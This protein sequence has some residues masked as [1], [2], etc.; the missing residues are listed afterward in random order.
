MNATRL[1]LISVLV[2]TFVSGC[3]SLHFTQYVV[4]NASATDRATIKKAIVSS[5]EAAGLVDKTE[6][7]KIPDTIVYYLE[8]VPHFPVS[9]GARMVQDSAVVDLSCF[10]PGT[11]KP[12][13]FQSVE[14]NLTATF[15]REFGARLAMPDNSHSVPLT[16]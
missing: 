8:P 1:L 5:A 15:T 3:D 13:I 14:S 6:T 12:L 4:S 16:K 10:H 11:E 2:I 7:S 9:L